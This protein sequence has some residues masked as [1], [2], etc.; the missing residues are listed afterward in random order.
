MIEQCVVAALSEDNFGIHASP[1]ENLLNSMD[2]ISKKMEQKNLI[3]IAN[4]NNNLHDKITDIQRGYISNQF[5]RD[6][7]RI[8]GNP[9]YIKEIF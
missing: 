6:I 4:S 2:F 9:R 5:Q 1:T 3:D 8:E 7:K